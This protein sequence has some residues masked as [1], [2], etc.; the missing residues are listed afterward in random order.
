MHALTGKAC[1][2]RMHTENT[3]TGKQACIHIDLDNLYVYLNVCA[4]YFDMFFH[5]QLSPQYID[6]HTNTCICMQICVKLRACNIC[7]VLFIDFIVLTHV[8]AR[9]YINKITLGFL[10]YLVSPIWYDI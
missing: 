10:R 3:N 7:R 4:C 2:T 1:V 8:H 6:M 9:T 5:M